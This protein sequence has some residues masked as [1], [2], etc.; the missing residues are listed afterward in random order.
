MS[1][2]HTSRHLS[3]EFLHDYL[4]AGNRAVV[5]IAG[6]PTSH[7]IIDAPRQRI[8]VEVEWDGSEL[9]D[10]ADYVH[11]ET[12][13]AF[14]DGSNWAQLWIVD[15]RVLVDGYSML[16]LLVD[17]VQE[18][19]ISMASAIPD[20]LASFKRLLEGLDRLGPQ[21][22]VGLMG[23]LIVL[24][25]L[26]GKLGERSATDSWLGGDNEEHDFAIAS[27]DVEVKTTTAETRRHWIA[28]HT[29]L[30]P[31]PDR[32]LVLVSIQLTAGIEQA[33]TLTEQVEHVRHAVSDMTRVEIDD[34][35]AG[36]GWR[37]AHGPQYR[38]R[39][40]LRSRPLA[41]DVDAGFPAIT[42]ARLASAGLPVER[43]SRVSYE[44]DVSGLPSLRSLPAFLVDFAAASP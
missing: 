15:P 29:Q 13:I 14:H 44:V 5:V 25:H 3:S 31:S 1:E 21:E 17:K 8:G 37:E 20:V 26:I 7:L 32:T 34:R 40:R 22:E 42:A 2:A 10:L 18:G 24:D 38:R 41:F 4:R 23:E 36:L 27:V 30:T 33:R 35:L 9:P 43:L 19:G 28:S 6:Q 11:L 39:F 12:S 16:C